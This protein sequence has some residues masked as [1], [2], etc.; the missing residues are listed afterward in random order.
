MSKSKRGKNKDF[1]FYHCGKAEKKVVDALAGILTSE[2]FLCVV[3]EMHHKVKRLAAICCDF[4]FGFP[5]L[6]TSSSLGLPYKQ[7]DSK[8]GR[9][10]SQNTLRNST[11]ATECTHL[12]SHVSSNAFIRHEFVSSSGEGEK[13]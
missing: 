1:V 9:R 5:S 10:V 4:T 12:A 7:G 11:A 6:P 13:R 8:E 3:G 2:F